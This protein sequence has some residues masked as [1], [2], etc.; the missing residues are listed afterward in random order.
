M[1]HRS[2]LMAAISEAN[3][4]RSEAASK[5]QELKWHQ[6]QLCKAREQL[7]D[8]RQEAGQMHVSMS[9]MV[10]KSVLAEVK[11]AAESYQ[12]TVK[13]LQEKLRNLQHDKA[14]LQELLQVSLQ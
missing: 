9:N 8:A 3:A 2:E 13:A 1:V 6:E 12:D 7:L 10:Q 4:N 11:T 5:D 14:A